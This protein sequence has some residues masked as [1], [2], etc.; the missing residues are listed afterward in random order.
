ML[1]HRK[2]AP[3]VGILLQRFATFRA[4]LHLQFWCKRRHDWMFIRCAA[5]GVFLGKRAATRLLIGGRLSV[6]RKSGGYH[7]RLRSALTLLK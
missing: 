5:V 3:A 1:T 4:G 6:H 2:Y 7:Q